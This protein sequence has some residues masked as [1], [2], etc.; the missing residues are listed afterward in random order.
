MPVRGTTRGAL[1][2]V[3][4]PDDPADA[5]VCLCQ[6]GREYLHAQAR[7]NLWPDDWIDLTRGRRTERSASHTVEPTHSPTRA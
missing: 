1:D 7:P 5:D 4:T 2:L 6:P 3:I